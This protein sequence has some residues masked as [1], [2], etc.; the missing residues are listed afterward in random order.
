VLI[1]IFVTP[2]GGTARLRLA[3]SVWALLVTVRVYYAAV[4]LTRARLRSASA[5]VRRVAWLP[6]GLFATAFV[7]IAVG[8]AS[9]L[10]PLPSGTDFWVHVARAVSTGPTRLVLWPFV[11]ILRPALTT[12][13]SSFAGAFAASLVILAALMAWMLANDVVL[14]SALE[15]RTRQREEPAAPSTARSLRRS[16]PWA[17]APSGRVEFV[18]LW[19]GA[20]QTFRAANFPVWRYL[21]PLLGLTIGVIGAAA[22]IASGANMQGPASFVTV[23]GCLVAGVATVFGPQMMRADLRSDFEHL[24]VLKTWPVRAGDVIRGEMAWPVVA[25]SGT[26]CLAL[27]IAALFSGTALPNVPLVSRWSVAIAWI[28]AAPSIIA[29]QYAV[30]NAATIAFPAWVPLG[31]QARARGI[32]AMGQRLILLAAILLSLLLLSVPG[33]IASGAIWLTLHRIAGAVVYVPMAVVFAAIMLAEV[34]VVTELLGP[35][36]EGIDVTSVERPE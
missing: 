16:T 19:K 21:P 13:W 14:D 5:S 24:D 17:L 36:Y 10:R 29:A 8:L 7:V 6:I 1:A 11:A 2:L 25:V 9:Q 31:S 18:F 27:L 15:Q 4:T 12:T 22:G 28:V 35:A 26:A 32:D 30:H 23:L 34:I 33:A 3:M 20:I